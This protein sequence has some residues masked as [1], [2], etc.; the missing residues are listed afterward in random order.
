VAV[1]SNGG[2]FTV[3][4]P[5]TFTGGTDE[6]HVMLTDIPTP[7]PLGGN[8][9]SG[10]EADESS[11]FSCDFEDD[12]DEYCGMTA[13]AEIGSASVI[14]RVLANEVANSFY[15]QVDHTHRAGMK[16]LLI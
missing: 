4:Y 11:V 9:I 12:D 16:S 7:Q 3:L 5:N 15:P 10:V 2:L 13:E 1:G 14:T 8:D 6:K